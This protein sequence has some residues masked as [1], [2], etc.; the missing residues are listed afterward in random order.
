MAHNALPAGLGPRVSRPRCASRQNTRAED[1]VRFVNIRARGVC[2]EQSPN[3]TIIS[4]KHQ[5]MGK[6]GLREGKQ[7]V[8]SHTTRE[9][10]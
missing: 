8:Q 5:K 2:R 6:L 3:A 9:G 4:S 1:I 7:P 10:T